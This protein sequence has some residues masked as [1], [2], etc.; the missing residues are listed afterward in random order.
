MP[1]V[2]VREAPKAL[3]IKSLGH[4]PRNSSLLNIAPLAQSGLPDLSQWSLG[5]VDW[6]VIR[7]WQ[8]S[9]FLIGFGALVR[10]A[11]KQIPLTSTGV[12]ANDSKIC[13]GFQFS[14][15]H[16]GWNHDYVA[17]IHLDVAAVL[18][19]DSQ[20]RSATINS[21]RFMRGAVVMRKGIDAV[22][23]RV[24]PVVL[25]KALFNNGSAIRL[26]CERLSIDQQ[27]QDAVWENAVV[28]KT[29]LFRRDEFLLF[30]RGMGLHM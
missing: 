9:D 5:A 13:A 19:A 4:R 28:L 29:E 11:S 27:R 6:I 26:R 25:R 16:T 17:G 21:K 1:E 23:P 24:G 18:A 15:S 7:N 3:R 12:S 22:S 14:V 10:Q 20:G 30:N 2:R 8:G